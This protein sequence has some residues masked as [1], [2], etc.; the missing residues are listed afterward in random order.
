MSKQNSLRGPALVFANV[1]LK[2]GG[3]HVL[4]AVNFQVEAGALH[5]LVGPNGGGKT[6]LVRALLGHRWRAQPPGGLCAA[7]GG[8]RPQRTD[9]RL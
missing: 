6:S 1:S 4:D 9:D 2:L 3:S 7:T 8:L 5:C